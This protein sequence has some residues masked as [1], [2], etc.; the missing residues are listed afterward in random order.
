[1]LQKY[2]CVGD[3][4]C[5]KGTQCDQIVAK[6]LCTVQLGDPGCG[7]GTQCEQIVAKYLCAGGPGCGKG[8]QC[9][10]IVAKGGA[11]RITFSCQK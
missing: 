3:P 10:Q 1:M 2:L 4:G 7:K 8:T 11:V 5:D 6:Y 9:E